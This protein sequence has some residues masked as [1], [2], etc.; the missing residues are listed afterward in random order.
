MD[1]L[2]DSVLQGPETLSDVPSTRMQKIEI[3][4]TEEPADIFDSEDAEELP[5]PELKAPQ[6]F[7]NG[8]DATEAGFRLRWMP[9]FAREA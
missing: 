9:R 8:T 6:N 3:G 7:G 2:G 1:T 4:P 5:A